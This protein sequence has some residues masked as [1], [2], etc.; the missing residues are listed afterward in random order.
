MFLQRSIDLVS[1]PLPSS[2]RRVI[3]VSAAWKTR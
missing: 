1:R 3:V 2:V